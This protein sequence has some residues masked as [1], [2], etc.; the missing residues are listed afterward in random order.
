MKILLFGEYNRAHRF[1]K[2]GLQALGH[3]S[4]VIGRKDAFK[5]VDVD[6][7]LE[8]T[9]FYHKTASYIRRVFFRLTAFDLADVE[10][11]YKF[12]KNRNKLR[13]Y[14]IVQLINEFPLEIHP[15]FEKQCLTYLFKNNNKIILSACGD[16]TVY[17][18]YL[19]N[20]NLDYHLMKPYQENKKLKKYYRFNLKFLKKS[21]KK[22][23]AYIFENI[24]NVIP[25][26]FDYVMAYRNHLKALALIP[27]PINIS[28]FEYKTPKIDGRVIIFHGI[29]RSNYYRKGNFYFEDALE[30]IKKKYADK[31]EIITVENKP[32]KEYI[33]SFDKAHIL[34]DQVHAYDQGYNALEAMAKGKV[35][36]TGA[37]KEWLTHYKL[38]ENTVAIN[39]LP[40]AN[41]IA[42]KLEWLILHPEKIIKISKNGREF[43]ARE[44]DHIKSAQLY[45]KAWNTKSKT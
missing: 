26:D 21:H 10:I 22:L 1:L 24:E 12:Y 33:K 3:D 19:L 43:V 4:I 31:I 20:S 44:H 34:L 38:E 45:L 27:H 7:S 18:D 39:A 28:N 6:V 11:F 16:D 35:V 29:N 32:Y 30:I 42:D 8:T 5:K 23:S 41:A 14:D 40:D 25:A 15:F 13:G 2:E 37:E 17:V 9:F 36:F